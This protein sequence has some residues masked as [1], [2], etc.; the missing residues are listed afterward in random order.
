MISD[1]VQSSHTRMSDLNN[2]NPSHGTATERAQVLALAKEVQASGLAHGQSARMRHWE[3]VDRILD[4]LNCDDRLRS[5]TLLYFL[6]DSGLLTRDRLQSEFGPDL[7]ALV[8]GIETLSGFG[9]PEEWRPEM[10]L[11]PR[12][13]ESLRQMLVAIASD[14][15]LVLVRLADQLVRLQELRDAEPEKTRKTALE[16]REIFAPLANRLGVWQIKWQLEDLAFRYLDPDAYG[17]LAKA[18]QESRGERIAY[19]DNF[20][21]ALREALHEEDVS[22]EVAG[23]AKHL[24]SIWRKMQK[25]HLEVDELFDLRAVRIL[26]DTVADCYAALGVVHSRWQYIPGEFDDYIATPKENGYRSLHT[27]VMGPGGHAVEVQIR[28]RDMHNRAELGVAAH[29]RYKEGR[30]QDAAFDQKIQWLRQILEPEDKDET[31]NDLID[32]VKSEISEDRVYVISPRGEI[33]DLPAGSTPL[34]FAY[35]VHSEIGHHCRGAKVNGR[36][37]TLTYKLRTGEQVEIV[38]AKN[39]SPSRDWLVPQFG[40]I[41]SPRTRAKVRN[42]FRRQNQDQNRR[43]GKAMLDKEL[44]R[45]GIKAFP[46]PQLVKLL[47]TG[48]AE[49]LHGKIGSGDLSLEA[50]SDAVQQHQGIAPDQPPIVIKRKRKPNK[51]NRFVIAGLGDLLSNPARCCR[52]M[53]PEPIRGYL[54]QGRG[55]SIHRDNCTNLIRLAV[56]SPERILEVTWE[57]GDADF[58]PVR[59]RLEAHDRPGLARDVASL[60]SDENVHI[61]ALEARS[62]RRDNSAVMELLI[63]VKG[64]DQLSRVLN[65]LSTLPNVTS[66]NRTEH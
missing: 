15:R 53:P 48:T 34:D 56:K 44:G 6:I 19:L 43:H 63:E 42:W 7:H 11:P 45:L 37:V 26:V 61:N 64:L 27:A 39:S 57:T 16:T 38:T 18:L 23:R 60:L 47:R 1:I 59:I 46:L 4:D 49:E 52:P 5:G 62:N 25:K 13:A 8:A 54:T 21:A 33:V 41:A 31:A 3:A 24:Y 40:Y 20:Q 58:Y 65:R 12:Q 36:M 9:L 22:A 50:V 29:W 2:T 32:R 51:G 28:T 30:S 14:V 17:R 10:Q 35:H 66:V 55:V